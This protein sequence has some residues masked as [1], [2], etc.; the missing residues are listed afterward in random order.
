MLQRFLLEAYADA[1]VEMKA[2]AGSLRCFVG[3]VA[4]YNNLSIGTEVFCNGLCGSISTSL[5]GS[6][7]T[8]YNCFPQT[9][10]DTAGLNATC[11]TIFLD[12]DLT[13]CCCNTDNCNTAGTNINTTIPVQPAEEPVACYSGWAI[14]GVIN[15]C[16]DL[17]PGVVRGCCCDWDACINPT[18]PDK[19]L[20]CYV[21]M[22]APKAGINVGAEV[23]C[24]GRC[25]SLSGVVNGDNVV[26][27][28]CVPRQVC[29]T[30]VNANACATLQGDRE[31]TG[32]C[33]NDRDSCNIYQQNVTGIVIPT[34]SPAV[35]FP[36]SCWSGIYVNGAP[37]TSVGFTTCNGQ[38]ASV[39]LNTTINGVSHTA[40]LY[41]CDPTSVCQAL[42]MTN[43]CNIYEPGI[44]GC[45]CDTDACIYPPKNR[46]PA[47]RL[48]CYVGMYAPKAGVNVGGEIACD[49]QCSSLQGIVN[50]DTVTTFQCAPLSVCKSLEIDNACTSLPGDREV[51]GCCCDN[52]N[53]CNVAN[54]SMI[55]PPTAPSGSD[56]PISCWSGVYVNG[57]PITKAGYMSCN[58]DCAS[59]T[60]QTTLNGQQHNATMYM[61]DPVAVC[62]A[63][64]RLR[65]NLL[66]PECHGQ[67]RQR[68]Y[69]PIALGAYNSCNTLKG[70]R[71]VTGCCCDS[72]NSCNT[73]PGSPGNYLQCYVG[74]KAPNAGVNV[75]AEV[76]CDGMCSSLSGVVN[77]DKV[78]TFQCAP[79]SVCKSL[80]ID[81]ACTGLPGDREIS[82]CCCDYANSCNLQMTNNTDV[83]SLEITET[84]SI[85]LKSG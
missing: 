75:G 77:G 60:L 4:D 13:G 48:M 72:S 49:G 74:I 69:L 14:N 64:N 30:F 19:P 81:N 7:F 6:K 2:A 67:W 18:V 34:P 59:V 76:Y 78:T 71:E 38:C 56:F 63:L 37:M 41:T 44:G 79:I 8:T 80:G 5:G 66:F 58:G 35:E 20:M 31:I 83:S 51:T 55:I 85:S 47:N 27:F 52:A 65:R 40:S 45:C 68:D 10:C 17:E 43:K 62:Q 53:N 57:N 29:K 33:C 9:F 46:S 12:R 84:N 42:N 39:T 82:G 23:A 32:C 22:L 15:K 36:I 73:P 11:T 28:H 26:T 70:D 54:Y 21:G 3:I 25:A 16:M 24:T 1:A 61:C 50:G